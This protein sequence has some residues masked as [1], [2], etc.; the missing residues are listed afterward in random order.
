LFAEGSQPAHYDNGEALLEAEDLDA[1]II[2]SPNHAHTDDAVRALP[3]GIPLL[4]EKPV[5]INVD[6]CRRLWRAYVDAGQ[7]PVTVGFVLRYSGFYETIKAMLD[8]GDLGQVLSIDA[9]EMLG[10][11][12][13]AYFYRSWRRWDHLTGGFIVEKCCHD[14]DILNWLTEAHAERVYSVARRTHFTPRPA[15]ERHAR[16]E[17]TQ[18]ADLDFGDEQTQRIFRSLTDESP[19]EAESDM[20]DHQVVVIE[21]DNGVL[22]SFTACLAQPRTARRMR[23]YG[24]DGALEGDIGRSRIMVD[25]PAAEP[26]QFDTQD[27]VIPDAEG[28]HHGADPGISQAFWNTALG[29]PAQIRAGIREGIEAVLV[30]LAAEESKKT[31][32]PVDVARMR[33]EVFGSG[34]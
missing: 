6:E 26:D 4:L 11:G 27:P 12:L 23:I 2:A 29:R 10:A 14:L 33:A 18:R 7:P 30:G 9:D 25:R 1:L 8:R 28:G 5:A 32:M 17:P 13:T 24:S 22:S 21:F 20:P 3:R 15:D 34:L 16:F 31:G 19:Y